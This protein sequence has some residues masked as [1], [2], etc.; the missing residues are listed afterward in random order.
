MSGYP[1]TAEGLNRT[2]GGGKLSLLSVPLPEL[3]HR[4]SASRAPASQ[5]FRLRLQSTP[6]LSGSGLQTMSLISWTSSLQTDT[7]R[8]LSLH[9]LH[10]PIPVNKSFCLPPCNAD[11]PLE[12]APHACLHILPACPDIPVSSHGKAGL[13]ILK[14]SRKQKRCSFFPLSTEKCPFYIILVP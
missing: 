7:T 1:P 6:Q 3:K 8:P 4:S 14:S 12:H 9:K 11:W 5:A 2:K 13:G 10:E